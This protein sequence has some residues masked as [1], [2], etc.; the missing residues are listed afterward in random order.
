[1]FYLL[2]LSATPFHHNGRTV[3]RYKDFR[4]AGKRCWDTF[5]NCFFKMYCLSRQALGCVIPGKKKKKKKVF[6]LKMTVVKQ[7]FRCLQFS[8][9]KSP[10]WTHF[11]YRGTTLAAA[12]VIILVTSISRLRQITKRRC[13]SQAPL[14]F[15]TLSFQ[16]SGG[17]RILKVSILICMYSI[18]ELSFST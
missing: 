8:F 17:V 11:P 1:M 13:S 12:T 14:H 2:V 9:T 7:L 6:L 3:S 4:C 10:S 16:F 18:F 15:I 5:S